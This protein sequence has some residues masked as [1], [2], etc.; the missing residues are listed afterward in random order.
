LQQETGKSKSEKKGSKFGGFTDSLRGQQFRPADE[1]KK[2]LPETILDRFSISSLRA[3]M[4]KGAKILRKYDIES[5]EVVV[6]DDAGQGRYLI[7][8]PE[9]SDEDRELY[10]LLMAQL[11]FSVKPTLQT[12]D[13]VKY[14]ENFIEEISKEYKLSGKLE[15]SYPQLRY[16]MSREI[17]G[18]S[19][20]NVPMKDPRV[21]EVECSGFNVPVTVVHR[22]FSQFL[23]LETNIKYPKPEN[24]D[25]M[26]QK[27]SQRAGKS[28]TVAYPFTD[29]LLPEGHRGAVTYSNEVSL[30]GSTFDIRKFPEEPLSVTD[31][32]ASG[33]ISPLLAAATPRS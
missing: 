4:P 7:N 21:E 12:T 22:D 18:Y 2:K 5:A 1:I 29:F 16:Y 26:V 30:P 10:R 13:P 23:R 31:L 3:E 17:A 28:T 15:K 32:I 33:T 14:V 20:L 27:F 24:V 6:V 19:M 9:V 11:Y 8:E 25:D